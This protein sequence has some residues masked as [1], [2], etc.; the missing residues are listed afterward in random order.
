MVYR[1]YTF[2]NRK[3]HSR[4]GFKLLQRSL[5]YLWSVHSTTE[6]VGPLSVYYISFLLSSRQRNNRFRPNCTRTPSN[7]TISQDYHTT[8][9]F[10][11]HVL[12]FGR[13]LEFGWYSD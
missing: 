8:K 11:Y 6:K 3:A 9:Y 7:Q 13:R 1:M 4:T 10:T 12:T 2:R 5:N